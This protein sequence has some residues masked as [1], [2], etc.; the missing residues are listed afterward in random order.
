MDRLRSVDPGSMSS[1][2]ITRA[3]EDC[4]ISLIV[5]PA[6][7]INPPMRMFGTKSRK[8]SAASG[9]GIGLESLP[10]NKD[11]EMMLSLIIPG[12]Y[13]ELQEQALMQHCQPFPCKSKY[14]LEPASPFDALKRRF[15]LESVP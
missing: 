7:P 12:E 15:E 6:F 4:W 3:E 2:A 1:L 14:V 10:Y 11:N 5:A 9:S 13:A 8:E